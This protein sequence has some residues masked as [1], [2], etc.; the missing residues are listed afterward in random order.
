[1]TFIRPPE[2]WPEIALTRDI[3]IDTQ[4]HQVW[5]VGLGGP[6]SITNDP[7]YVPFGGPL[8]DPLVLDGNVVVNPRGFRVHM[9]NTKGGTP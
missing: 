9:T 5:V 8:S 1:M 7:S 3:E 4:G 6:I 2:D